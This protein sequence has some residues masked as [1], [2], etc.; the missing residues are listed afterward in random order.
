MRS[1]A[2]EKDEGNGR[3]HVKGQKKI[4]KLYTYTPFPRLGPV[5]CS[6]VVGRSLTARPRSPLVHRPAATG[7]PCYVGATRL[8]ASGAGRIVWITNCLQHKRFIGRTVAAATILAC[9]RLSLNASRVPSFITACYSVIT[10]LTLDK[11]LPLVFYCAY[12]PT[13]GQQ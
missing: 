1:I 4:E 5:R 7:N 13:R 10:T 2:R 9:R 11:R 8:S 6:Q 12:W 3:T